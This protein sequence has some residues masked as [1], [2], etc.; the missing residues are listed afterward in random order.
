M[1]RHAA[2]ATQDVLL[3]L[4]LCTLCLPKRRRAGSRA[5]LPRPQRAFF[6]VLDRLTLWIY[7]THG[8]LYLGPLVA[9]ISPNGNT[10]ALMILAPLV[11]ADDAIGRA[12][13]SLS[14][15]T[16]KN[17]RI[18]GPPLNLCDSCQALLVCG[19]PS[20]LRGWMTTN[21]CQSLFPTRRYASVCSHYAC[22]RPRKEHRESRDDAR[23]MLGTHHPVQQAFYA[24]GHDETYARSLDVQQSLQ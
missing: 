18:A 20:P 9:V 15:K 1:L 7:A 23:D 12:Q 5:A 2:K 3:T 4:W 24:R 13:E 22:G 16:P 10:A 8:H 14:S 17:N 11:K 6:H 21:V 19:L